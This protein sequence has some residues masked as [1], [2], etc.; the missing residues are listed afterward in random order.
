MG[1]PRLEGVSDYQPFYGALPWDN[2]SDPYKTAR[3]L[4]FVTSFPEE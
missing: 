1:A 2:S 3:T 4:A